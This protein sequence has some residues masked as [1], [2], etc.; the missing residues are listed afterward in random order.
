MIPAIALMIATYGTARLLN[1]C[2][3]AEGASSRGM[4]WFLSLL[5]IAALWLLAL[6]VVASGSSLSNLGI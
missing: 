4:M 3:A 5:A 6:S 1:D 2:M